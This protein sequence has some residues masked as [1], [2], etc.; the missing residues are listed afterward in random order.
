MKWVSARKSAKSTS[1]AREAAIVP[2]PQSAGTLDAKELSSED[3]KQSMLATVH[4]DLGD[5]PPVMSTI[6][7]T[8]CASFQ[9][10]QLSQ[11]F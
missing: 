10:N 9:S 5:T 8:Q 7:E 2:H 3:R 1:S 4:V 6:V 11:L